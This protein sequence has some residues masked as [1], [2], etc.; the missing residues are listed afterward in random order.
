MMSVMGI[1]R[2]TRGGS[3]VIKR[4]AASGFAM[5]PVLVFTLISFLALTASYERLR[6]LFAYEESSDRVPAS[7]DGIQEALGKGI[8]SRVVADAKVEA[9]ALA[10]AQRIAD[11]A[12][13]VH[14]WHRKFLDR[15]ADPTP[16]SEEEI[17][18]TY[19]CFDTEDFQIGTR[20][21]LDKTKPEFRGR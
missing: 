9:E 15:M 21:F 18:E 17:K 14:R 2:V 13:L 5:V 19:A 8:V 10:T 16:P 6:Q 3:M 1:M 12:P 7:S 20:S 4:A 11:G